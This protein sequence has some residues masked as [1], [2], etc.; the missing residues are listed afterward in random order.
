[1]KTAV[2]GSRS[3]NDYELLMKIIDQFIVT[4]II[5]GGA[6]GADTL[7][8]QYAMEKGIPAQIYKPDYSKFGRRAP[9]MRNFTIIDQSQQVIAFWDGSSR[10]TL[11]ALNYAKE[12]ERIIYVFSCQ[13]EQIHF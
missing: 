7:G 6:I 12:K 4:E 2:I 1:M 9:L 3:F 5:S 10:G 13:G 11:Q 8:E